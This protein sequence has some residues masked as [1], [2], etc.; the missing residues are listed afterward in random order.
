LAPLEAMLAIYLI[1][2]IYDGRS[3]YHGSYGA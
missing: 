3:Q 2:E 1:K